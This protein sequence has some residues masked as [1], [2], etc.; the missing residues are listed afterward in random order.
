MALFPL[1]SLPIG[2][3]FA[4]LLATSAVLAIVS[5]WRSLA[6]DHLTPRLIALR[7]LLRFTHIAG[8]LFNATY[9]LLAQPTVIVD[10]IFVTV[11]FTVILLWRFMKR[12]CVLSY[13]DEYI[14]DPSYCIGDDPFIRSYLRDVFGGATDAIATA[15]NIGTFVGLFYTLFRVT[16]GMLPVQRNAVRAVLGLTAVYLIAS[17]YL[18]EYTSNPENL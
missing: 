17:E 2:T 7:F 16:Q 15:S 14:A 5:T 13:L 11:T 12:E 18:H 8:L 3:Y 9:V 10:A 6:R 4:V 1:L